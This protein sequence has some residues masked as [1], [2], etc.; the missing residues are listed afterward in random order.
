MTDIFKLLD[1][2]PTASLQAL[3][4]MLILFEPNATFNFETREDFIFYFRLQNQSNSEKCWCELID[5]GVINRETINSKQIYRIGKKVI[6]EI[7]TK[8]SKNQNITK[9]Y[10]DQIQFI[11]KAFCG[12][13][14]LL[15]QKCKTY[16]EGRNE[17]ICFDDVVQFFDLFK[18]MKP[19]HYI[20][21]F[22]TTE[23]TCIHSI[24]YLSKIAMEIKSSKSEKKVTY[25]DNVKWDNS[26]Q[27]SMEHDFAL[28]IATG[29]A[30]NRTKYKI[31]LS[32][33]KIDELRSYYEQGKQLLPKSKKLYK[34]Y[35]WL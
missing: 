7:P 4:L 27:V 1:K 32:Q 16:I 2:Y 30:L 21:F 10:S 18:G 9:Y 29:E 3:G 20:E 15:F 13:V 22:K 24:K 34:D 8:P 11:H 23:K 28:K 5:L 19:L 14:D 33:G 35:P 31:L 25:S 6:F 12:K 26:K 17:T